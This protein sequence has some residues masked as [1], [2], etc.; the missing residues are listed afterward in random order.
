MRIISIVTCRS[1]RQYLI[2]INDS[3]FLWTGN[4]CKYRLGKPIPLVSET[5][6]PGNREITYEVETQYW[7]SFA[8]GLSTH[9]EKP[10]VVKHGGLRIA[11]T[12]HSV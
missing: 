2:H 6:Y 3:S 4:Q 9:Y 11:E 12:H 5:V 10:G 7:F 1:Q 8:S